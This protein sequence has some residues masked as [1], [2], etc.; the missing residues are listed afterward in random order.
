[1]KPVGGIAAYG[2]SGTNVALRIEE[3]ADIDL[4]DE[5]TEAQLPDLMRLFGFA[6]WADRRTPEDVRWM[7]AASTIV[8]ALVDRRDERLVAF[9]RVL[10]DHT[11]LAIVLDVVVDP[12]FRGKGLGATLMNTIVGHPGL[13]DVHSVELVCQPEMQRFYRRWGFTDEVGRSV[14]MRRV[15]TATSTAM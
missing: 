10:T 4:R 2:A 12:D 11:Y 1:M 13:A 8:V 7:L 9:A 6:W 5:V 14:L 15:Q 3:E